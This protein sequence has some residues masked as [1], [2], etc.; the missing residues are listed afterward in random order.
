LKIQRFVLRAAKVYEHMDITINPEAGL[1]L[2][3]LLAAIPLRNES[4]RQDSETATS[5]RVYV[6]LRKKW[7]MQPPF[8][9]LF[10]FSK[11]RVIELDSLGLEVWR[12]CDGTSTVEKIITLFA[13]NH[14]LTFHESR[15]SVMEFLRLLT[16]RGIIVIVGSNPQ[17]AEH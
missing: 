6:P 12:M 14:K 5:V 10:R 4:V 9:W 15:L 3:E 1:S 13:N 17:E 2:P 8:S 16:R 7:F 11:E